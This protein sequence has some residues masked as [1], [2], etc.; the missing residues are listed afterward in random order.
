MKDGKLNNLLSIET[1]TENKFAKTAKATKRTDVAKDVLQEN[2][3][4]VG[5]DV[6]GKTK[7]EMPTGKGETVKVVGK[8]VL[9][10]G[11]KFKNTEVH[12]AKSLNNLISLDD[13]TKSVPDTK[14]HPTKRTGTAKDV[15]LEKKVKYDGDEDDDEVCTKK[16]KMKKGGK[17]GKEDDD[18]KLSAAQKKLP[19]NKGKK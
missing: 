3:Y 4:V 7:V 9:G 10:Q 8:D 18:K 2:A 14:D 5:K 1:F 13:F 15:I 17:K 11:E 16:E 19:W 6:F 12:A